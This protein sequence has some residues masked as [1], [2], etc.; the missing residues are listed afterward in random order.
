MIAAGA[1][2][3]GAEA[4]AAAAERRPRAARNLTYL[5]GEIKKAGLRWGVGRA[6]RACSMRQ[7]EAIVRVWREAD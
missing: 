3:T 1:T 2:V 6:R 7:E 5:A 4:A